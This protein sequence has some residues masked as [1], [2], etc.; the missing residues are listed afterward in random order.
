MA[1]LDEDPDSGL[2]I[3]HNEKIRTWANPDSALI[4]C[5]WL[6]GIPG[7]GALDILDAV[8]GRGPDSNRQDYS[9]FSHYRRM[10]EA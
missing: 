2:W 4:P 8:E 9:R 7:A 6:N 3:L 10:S 1:V 5:L